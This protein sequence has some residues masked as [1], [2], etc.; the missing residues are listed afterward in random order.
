MQFRIPGFCFQ[1]PPMHTEVQPENHLNNQGGFQ[2]WRIDPFYSDEQ[3][4]VA[5]PSDR[6]R[7]THE[8]RITPF[9]SSEAQSI[10]SFP[11]PQEKIRHNPLS[12]IELS[13]K[14]SKQTILNS[15]IEIRRYKSPSQATHRST[16]IIRD[17]L[18]QADFSQALDS[19]LNGPG[20]H[21]V[22]TLPPYSLL[23]EGNPQQHTLTTEPP[24]PYSEMASHTSSSKSAPNPARS[25]SGSPPYANVHQA[26]MDRSVE[27]LQ[28]NGRGITRLRTDTNGEYRSRTQ[29]EMVGDRLVNEHN[30]HPILARTIGSLSNLV[31]TQLTRSVR[32]F[33]RQ[34]SGAEIQERAS[35]QGAAARAELESIRA[36]PR[37]WG[38]NDPES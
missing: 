30:L 15:D 26:R 3:P 38:L 6:K 31:P 33:I 27:S 36:S 22:E 10:T 12:A 11:L 18:G 29:T 8:D 21:T 35:L 16:D 19:G 20:S 23:A 25:K 9:S 34:A 28:A 4:E 2:Q 32:S 13:N 24:P 7:T 37:P 1:K 5:I 14:I 17:R